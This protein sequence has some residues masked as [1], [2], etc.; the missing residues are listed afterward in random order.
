MELINKILTFENTTSLMI[1]GTVEKPY[2]MAN[3]VA[4]LL[5]YKNT[6]QAIND[7]VWPSYTITMK[8][9]QEIKPFETKHQSTTKLLSEAGLYQLIFASKMGDQAIKFQKWVFEEVLPSLRKTGEYKLP[10]PQHNQLMLL[11]EQDLHVKTVDFI[12]SK[13][14]HAFI[15]CCMGELQDTDLKRII[16]KMKGYYAGCT[17]IQ[18]FNPNDKYNGFAIEFKSPL[19]G[20]VMSD[21]QKDFFKRIKS[22]KWKTVCTSSYD[23]IIY[24]ICEYFKTVKIHCD[25]CEASFK[26]R[27]LLDKHIEKDHP[28]I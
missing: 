7:H 22:L 27:T 3:V 18:I 8:E 1:Y 21:K 5:G 14:P 4:K 2:F 9:L 26:N 24:E 25:H 28:D 10:K 20:G 13:F 16:S 15:M 17:D 19:T 12:K 6:N 11:N 23:D